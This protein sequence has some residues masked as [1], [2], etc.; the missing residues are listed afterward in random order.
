MK[1]EFVAETG[2]LTQQQLD[3]ESVVAEA[4][5]VLGALK[6]PV[7]HVP[8]NHD[9]VRSKHDALAPI[10]KKHF[11]EFIT[12]KE[13]HG[14]VCLFIYTEPLAKKFK[15][16][17]FDPLK[18]LRD[19]LKRANGKPVLV[20]HHT[21]SVGDF[22]NNKMHPG[23]DSQIRAQWIELLNEHNVK[24]VFAGHFHRDEFHWLGNVPLY[25]SSSVGDTLRRGRQATYR[26]YEYKDGRISYRTQYLK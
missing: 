11:G 20:F 1:I 7:Y 25:V 4:L 3:D 21:P 5:E 24:G 17:G 16:K 6:V 15:M 23:W 14:V 2:D 26:V 19:K 18:E 22:Y 8:G 12:E 10:Y 13:H 9:I